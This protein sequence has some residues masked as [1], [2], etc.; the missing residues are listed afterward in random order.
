MSEEID[1]KIH[2][3][4]NGC[5]SI[6]GTKEFLHTEVRA[7][8]LL[9]A[10]SPPIELDR[11]KSND[12]FRK[13]SEHLCQGGLCLRNTNI[14]GETC[15]SLLCLAGGRELR[16]ELGFKTHVN[17]GLDEALEMGGALKCLRGSAEFFA[18]K[19]TG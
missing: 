1:G 3:Q 5:S 12:F 4:K 15:S 8:S 18:R 14:I 7:P 16:G 13:K 9:I 10:W 6:N 2:A 17:G 19:R 11:V